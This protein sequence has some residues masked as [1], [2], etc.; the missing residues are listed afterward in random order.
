MTT[1][2]TNRE[3]F[4]IAEQAFH[5][6]AEGDYDTATHLL[7][8]AGMAS[9]RDLMEHEPHMSQWTSVFNN[10]RQRMEYEQSAQEVRDRV[11]ARGKA[12]T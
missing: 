6:A 11:A 12:T 8:T 9:V 5:L 10:A 7:S 4:K 1:R 3:A 2:N